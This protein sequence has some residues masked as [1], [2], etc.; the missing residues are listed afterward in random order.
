MLTISAMTIAAPLLA[1]GGA[2]ERDSERALRERIALRDRV[3]AEAMEIVATAEAL[4]AYLA[5]DDALLYSGPDPALRAAR[6]DLFPA[7]VEGAARR[8]EAL[9]SEGRAER[10]LDL[11]LR[12]RSGGA[13]EDLTSAID[14]ARVA[15]ALE[16]AAMLE[17]R[18]DIEDARRVA[19]IALNIDPDHPEANAALRRLDGAAPAAP[20]EAA[21]GD[22]DAGDGAPAERERPASLAPPANV[23]SEAIARRALER[24][25]DA[26][27]DRLDRALTRLERLGSESTLRPGAPQPATVELD[28]RLRDAERDTQRL[29]G[30]LRREVDRLSREVGSLRQELNRLR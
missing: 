15:R 29:V 26:L 20:A 30:D 18:G 8:A 2:G 6:A 21:P 25:V 27:S 24:R 14:R 10:A 9:I 28:R 22:A 19:L 3:V 1:Q 11:L 16:R 7:A 17:A 13:G 12:L 4:D 5:I 23:A